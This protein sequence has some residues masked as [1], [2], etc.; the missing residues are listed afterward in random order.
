MSFLVHFRKKSYQEGETSPSPRTPPSENDPAAKHQ[1]WSVIDDAE[2][3]EKILTK[4]A[5]DSSDW[6]VVL[7]TK[8]KLCGGPSFDAKKKREWQYGERVRKRWKEEAQ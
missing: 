7:A 2:E 3:E 6:V 8:S 5:L 4:L 1:K